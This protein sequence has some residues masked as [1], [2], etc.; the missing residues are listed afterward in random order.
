VSAETAR[1][2]GLA[3]DAVSGGAASLAAGALAV[4]GALVGE[5]EIGGE[6]CGPIVEFSIGYWTAA[7]PGRWS[8]WCAG[9]V[10]TCF[11]VA[12]AVAL[13]RGLLGRAPTML[14][15]NAALRQRSRMSALGSLSVDTLWARCAA[16][17]WTSQDL[18]QAQPGDL[19]FF[20]P[21][22]DLNHVG[23]V[24]GL[25]DGTIKTVEGN[26]GNAVRRRTYPVDFDKLF[27]LA[28]IP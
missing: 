22:G 17:R 15:V 23:L 21:E 2:L 25:A 5:A 6:N 7:E 1:L 10:S 4:A 8:R 16:L 19:V 11:L 3:V 14:E 13:Q 28:R 18:K 26:A 9:F 20:G 24:V 12:D 27:G